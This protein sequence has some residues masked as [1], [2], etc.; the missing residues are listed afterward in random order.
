MAWQQQYGH[1]TSSSFALGH[2]RRQWPAERFVFQYDAHFGFRG[3]LV[4]GGTS[5]VRRAGFRH[6]PPPAIRSARSADPRRSRRP[7]PLDALRAPSPPSGTFGRPSRA[8]IPG[9]SATAAA[10]RDRASC[11]R[12]P[13]LVGESLRYA[14]RVPR[15][16]GRAT[17]GRARRPSLEARRASYSQL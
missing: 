12:R 11:G 7:I 1:P 10:F 5:R 3:P 14:R 6:F 15:D 13:R 8:P 16:Q 2:R 4:Q 9:V 17:A